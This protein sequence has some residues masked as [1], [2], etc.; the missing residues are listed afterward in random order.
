MSHREGF[1][2]C[3]RKPILEECR[4]KL[5]YSGEVIVSHSLG[6][7]IFQTILF[8]K[9]TIVTDHRPLTWILCVKDPSSRLLRWRI[10]LEDYKMVYKKGS[11]NTNADALR[12]IHVTEGCTNRRATDRGQTKEDRLAIFRE[13][14]ENRLGEHLGMNRTY[15]RVR[16]FTT[17]PGMKQ[18]L[19][20]YIR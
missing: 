1:T 10:E 5:S 20:E 2:H 15:D 4:E 3:L 6:M 17:W 9:F 18:E 13:M 8:R 12:K 19:E 7:Q 11:N 14:H 16:L